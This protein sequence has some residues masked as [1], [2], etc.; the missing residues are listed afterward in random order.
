MPEKRS[1]A[2]D[3]KPTKRVKDNAVMRD[4]HRRGVICVI[5]GN[6]ASLH[7]IYPKGQGGDDVVD[8]LV[9]LCGHGTSGHHGEIEANEVTARITLGE[10]I[11][12]ERPDFVF[13]LQG[14]LGEEAAREWLRQKFFLSV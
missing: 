7:H 13:Y 9:G 1:Y 14:K 8:N 5:C 10:F 3:P 2:P 12:E 4:L 6:S 11:L